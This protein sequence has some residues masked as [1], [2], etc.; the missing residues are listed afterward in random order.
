MSALAASLGDETRQQGRRSQ[1]WGRAS[2]GLHSPRKCGRLPSTFTDVPNCSPRNDA[3]GYP[4][5]WRHDRL[6]LALDA[7]TPLRSL[8]KQRQSRLQ[9]Y[10]SS[11]RQRVVTSVAYTLRDDALSGTRTGGTRRYSASDACRL[12]HSLPSSPPCLDPFR[13]R[14]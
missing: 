9:W 14:L 10:T 8:I 6:I 2:V 1:T 7:S 11:R 3:G 12:N 5:R 4:S 13:S